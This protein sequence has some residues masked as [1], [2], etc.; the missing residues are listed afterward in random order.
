MGSSHILCIR[1]RTVAIAAA[2]LVVAGCVFGDKFYTSYINV[3][4]PEKTKEQV[5]LLVLDAGFSSGYKKGG[6]WESNGLS[7]YDACRQ[8]RENWS[9]CRARFM[10]N[11]T[12]AE[13]QD[14]TTAKEIRFWFDI[15]DSEGWIISEPTVKIENVVGGSKVEFSFTSFPAPL[16]L[17]EKVE[18]YSLKHLLTE[19]YGSMVTTKNEP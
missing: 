15:V 13:A 7:L 17:R 9:G 10:G 12:W 5:R 3:L 14:Q 16:R 4:F 8:V 1:I 18:F 19:R 6:R 2:C 11:S